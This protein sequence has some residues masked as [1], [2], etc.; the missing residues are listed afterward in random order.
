MNRWVCRHDQTCSS[1]R[2]HRNAISVWRFLQGGAR[3][4]PALLWFLS[5]QTLPTAC[6]R[7]APTRTSA[8][9]ERATC[10]HSL[11]HYGAGRGDGIRT[12]SDIWIREVEID[13][14]S[15]EQTELEGEEPWRQSQYW[16]SCS[17]SCRLT[18][19]VL[20]VFS[21]QQIA[22]C[23][24][25]WVQICFPGRIQQLVDPDDGNRTTNVSLSGLLNHESCLR[26]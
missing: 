26:F 25:S 13:P 15:A 2:F 22:V 17:R 18:R 4:T 14:T 8:D 7:P 23:V 6:L 11:L 19:V 20:C 12:R 21:K 5:V 1:L 9:P 16:L 3:Q 10:S 24:M